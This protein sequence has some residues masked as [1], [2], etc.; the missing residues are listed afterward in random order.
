[1][2]EGQWHKWW[3]S[4]NPAWR[5]RE[6]GRLVTG[7]GNGSWDSLLYYGTN[8]FVNVIGSLTAL[9]EVSTDEAEWA[10][11]LRDVRWVVGELLAVKTKQRCVFLLL[12]DLS[13]H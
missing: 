1:M 12:S 13:Q 11:N 3:D 4:L 9:L 7:V 6:N 2:F 8:G 10:R 5:V